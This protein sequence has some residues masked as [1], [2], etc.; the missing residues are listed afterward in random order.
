MYDNCDNNKSFCSLA[1]IGGMLMGAAIGA[2]VTILLTPS[3][4]DEVRR[5]LK[6]KG[7]EILKDAKKEVNRVAKEKVTPFIK[8]ARQEFEKA[9]E[10][11]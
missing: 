7:K 11:E 5:T 8:E 4:G 9:I 3:S 1:F 6:K 10:K 2:A